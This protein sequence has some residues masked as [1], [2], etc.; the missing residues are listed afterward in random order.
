MVEQL[1]GKRYGKLRVTDTYERRGYYTYWLCECDCGNKKYVCSSN[2][3]NGST[4][5]CGCERFK[6]KHGELANGKHPRLYNIWSNM[7]ARCYSQNAS[8]YERYGGVGIRVCDEWRNSYKSFATWAREHGYSEDLTIDRIDSK[9]NYEPFNCRWATRVEQQ[10]NRKVNRMITYNG[11]DYTVAQL[12]RHL[13]INQSTL[14]VRL[15]RGW[16]IE[17]A[18]AV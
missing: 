15:Y 17:R 18:T 6:K 13:G 3:K 8:G 9:G 10:N 1:S 14:R 16:S 2:L 12:A 4:K 11:K 5:S 7:I